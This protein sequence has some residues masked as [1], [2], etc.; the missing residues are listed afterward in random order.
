M[1]IVKVNLVG[2]QSPNRKGHSMSFFSSHVFIFTGL[3]SFKH[4]FESFIVLQQYDISFFLSSRDILFLN[5]N[6]FTNV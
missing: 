2:G 5:S 6:K 4:I 3:S 1:Q